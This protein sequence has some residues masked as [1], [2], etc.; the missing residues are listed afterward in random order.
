MLEFAKSSKGLAAGLA[1]AVRGKAEA[2]V[3]RWEL[4]P[5]R[6]RKLYLSLAGVMKVGGWCLG[7][8]EGGGQDAQGPAVEDGLWCKG[9]HS[10]LPGSTSPFQSSSSSSAPPAAEDDARNETPYLHCLSAPF[11]AADYSRFLVSPAI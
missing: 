1:P 3:S 11:G 8:L 7:A 2:W 9:R 10:A 4:N 6:A 5:S